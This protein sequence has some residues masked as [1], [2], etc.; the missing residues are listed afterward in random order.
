MLNFKATGFE[1]DAAVTEIFETAAITLINFCQAVIDNE[2]LTTPFYDEPGGMIWRITP[3]PAR[4]H[5]IEFEIFI[6]YSGECGVFSRKDCETPVF[7]MFAKRRV[8]ATAIVMELMRAAVLC[9]EPS[10]QKDRSRFPF[11][12]FRTL[13]KAWKAQGWADGLDQ[14]IAD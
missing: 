4:Q 12:E 1:E 3:V 2:A 14:L 10:Y 11:H 5:T 8:L 13:V 6:I 7:R 9:Q